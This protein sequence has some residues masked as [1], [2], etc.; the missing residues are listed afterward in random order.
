MDFEGEK[1]WY[2]Q[3][4]LVCQLRFWK[5]FLI[6]F[7]EAYLRK[8]FV[9]L[10][11]GVLTSSDLTRSDYEQTNRLYLSDALSSYRDNYP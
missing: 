7:R 9:D 6:R 3:M 4:L 11:R 5:D 2:Q 1:M 8:Q 10:Y